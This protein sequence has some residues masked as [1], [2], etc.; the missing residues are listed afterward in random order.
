MCLTQVIA[1]AEAFPGGAGYLASSGTKASMRQP[2]ET[3][4]D[5]IR[6]TQAHTKLKLSHHLERLVESLR[7][8]HTHV[9]RNMEIVPPIGTNILRNIQE[10]LNESVCR[11]NR[12]A[13]VAESF[14]P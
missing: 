10:V 7:T 8:L 13:N 12:L 1:L 9:R 2:F 3:L 5:H 4:P 14:Q 6:L 11:F